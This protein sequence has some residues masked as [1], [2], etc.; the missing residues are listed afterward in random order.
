MP[1]RTLGYIQAKQ[2]IQFL[3]PR[4]ARGTRANLL[5]L[6][7]LCTAAARVELSAKQELK[8]GS[9]MVVF[10]KKSKRTYVSNI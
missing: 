9:P 7:N 8:T 10:L 3:L 4:R 5:T 2:A 6:Y 1:L